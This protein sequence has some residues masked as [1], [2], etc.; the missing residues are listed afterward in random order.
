MLPVF[1]PVAPYRYLLPNLHLSVADI[2]NPDLFACSSR[3]WISLDIARFY[4]EHCQPSSGSAWPAWNT[5][6]VIPSQA[7]THRKAHPTDPSHCYAQ[8]PR[9]SRHSSYPISSNFSYHLKINIASDPDTRLHLPSSSSQQTS[10]QAS[11]SGNHLIIQL[12]LIQA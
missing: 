1:N 10:R 5:S 4:K 2:A 6:L 9:S 3:T 8:Q 7:R 11:A 12:P